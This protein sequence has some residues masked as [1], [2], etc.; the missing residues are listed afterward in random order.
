MRAKVIRFSQIDSETMLFNQ[1]DLETCMME[2][3]AFIIDKYF[4][5]LFCGIFFSIVNICNSLFKP[6]R[7]KCALTCSSIDHSEETAF[8][9]S[10]ILVMAFGDGE[11]EEGCA[12][13]L[14]D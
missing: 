13:H 4:I 2:S 11:S 5:A 3:L 6:I 10:S 1:I 14:S 12:G 7:I 9:I 8:H